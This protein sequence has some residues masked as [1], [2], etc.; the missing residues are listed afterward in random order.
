MNIIGPEPLIAG[1]RTGSNAKRSQRAYVFRSCPMTDTA[2]VI[3]RVRGLS[4]E[5]PRSSQVRASTVES[6]CGQRK[7]GAG[8]LTAGKPRPVDSAEL[9]QK[10]C[11]LP[12]KAWYK[13][14]RK[15]K[16]CSDV[17]LEKR[18]VKSLGQ[19]RRWTSR[20]LKP[21]SIAATASLSSLRCC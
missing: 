11:L 21:S 9:A 2:G 6:D 7:P 13:Q 10:G 19:P 18:G 15:L 3:C 12:K 17:A 8:L 20:E 5:R 1:I 4:R 16:R 14:G